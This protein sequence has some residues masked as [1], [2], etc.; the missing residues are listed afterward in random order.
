M[1]GRTAECGKVPD[2]GRQQVHVP[3][4][5]LTPASKMA[6]GDAL[7]HAGECRIVKIRPQR[8]G[9]QQGRSWSPLLAH[10]L[11]RYGRTPRLHRAYPNFLLNTALDGISGSPWGDGVQRTQEFRQALKSLSWYV[12]NR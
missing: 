2:V 5:S 8:G 7:I 10:T 4:G 1:P 11:T 12:D 9:R 6:G 3:H